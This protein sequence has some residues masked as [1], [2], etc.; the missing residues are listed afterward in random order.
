VKIDTSLGQIPEYQYIYVLYFEED[1]IT[2]LDQFEDVEDSFKDEGFSE[3]EGSAGEFNQ[4]TD[5]STI[6]DIDEYPTQ[7]EVIAV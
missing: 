4:V 1:Y 3:D 6:T 2:E 7:L 5:S